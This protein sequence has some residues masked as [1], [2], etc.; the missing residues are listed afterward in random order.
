MNKIQT[1]TWEKY[2]K[3]LPIEWSYKFFKTRYSIKNRIWEVIDNWT[4][5]CH[6][7][8]DKVPV[9]WALDYFSQLIRETIVQAEGSDIVWNGCTYETDFEIHTLH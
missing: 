6:Y 3:N 1:Q 2:I 9:K 4:I 8:P 7:N 5:C